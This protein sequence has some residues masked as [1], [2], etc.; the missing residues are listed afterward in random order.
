MGKT[1]LV[2]AFLAARPARGRV[3]RGACEP[4]STPGRWPR[5][6]TS[7]NRA[8][9]SPRCSKPPP[10]PCCSTAQSAVE[11]AVLHEPPLLGVL[12]DGEQIGTGIT[13]LVADGMVGA[14]PRWPWISS[15][16]P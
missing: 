9:G 6:P 2:E 14:D 5:W 7:R 13:A 1:S 8:P 3:L 12:P 16:A 10:T 11:R 15:S 4:L